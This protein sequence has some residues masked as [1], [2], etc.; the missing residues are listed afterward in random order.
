MQL[1]LI[2][3]YDKLDKLSHAQ[4]KLYNLTQDI[5]A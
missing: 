2:D 3:A 1:Q 4:L 5:F